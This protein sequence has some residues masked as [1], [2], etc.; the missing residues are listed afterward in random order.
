MTSLTTC[1]TGSGQLRPTQP[2]SG[3]LSRAFALAVLFVIQLIG[4][5][6]KSG[7]R[8]LYEG[9][10]DA[11]ATLVF[12][13]AGSKTSNQDHD[14]RYVSKLMPFIILTFQNSICSYL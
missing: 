11:K 3:T 1:I 14:E 8:F 2:L 13:P 10:D 6:P 4:W 9:G 12:A 5:H 7:F